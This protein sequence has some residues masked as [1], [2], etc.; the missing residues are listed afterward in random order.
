MT[1]T[2]NGVVADRFLLE[3]P[4]HRG[5]AEHLGAFEGAG[6]GAPDVIGGKR[7]HGSGGVAWD[8][9]ELT[10]EAETTLGVGAQPSFASDTS[11]RRGWGGVTKASGGS[12]SELWDPKLCG[13][14]DDAEHWMR[15][16]KDNKVRL[17]Y[18]WIALTRP[19]FAEDELARAGIADVPARHKALV[20]AMLSLPHTPLVHSTEDRSLEEVIA[21][22]KVAAF[23]AGRDEPG[24]ADFTSATFAYLNNRA[25]KGMMDTPALSKLRAALCDQI[26]SETELSLIRADLAEILD[27]QRAPQPITTART[28]AL[29]AVTAAAVT[30][31]VALGV[32][33]EWQ[34]PW[35]AQL[36]SSRVTG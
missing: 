31:I 1:T 25:V 19:G 33:Q 21:R 30:L 15:A 24:V 5:G 27:R 2:N 12:L 4:A 17:L 10:P 11:S 14:A 16:N 36:L 35:L 3:A 18:L 34:P 26:P 9:K 13:A 7:V 28:I 20:R 8:E 6:S 23:E 22:A 32:H 29:T